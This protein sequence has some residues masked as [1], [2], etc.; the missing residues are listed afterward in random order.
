MYDD[1]GSLE[2]PAT[3]TTLAR[4]LHVARQTVRIWAKKAGFEFQRGNGTTRYFD[5]KEVALIL[6]QRAPYW[7]SLRGRPVL[8]V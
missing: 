2:L 7:F 3:V 4:D 1:I 8:G 6:E 5:E